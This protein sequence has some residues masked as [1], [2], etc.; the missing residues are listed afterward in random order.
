MIYILLIFWGN[1]DLFLFSFVE[2]NV[3]GSNTY[4]I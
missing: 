1:V 4:E 2:I 3:Y